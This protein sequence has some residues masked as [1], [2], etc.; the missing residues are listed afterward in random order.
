[1][2]FVVEC[3]ACG[4]QYTF[5]EVLENETLTESSYCVATEGKCNMYK[6]VRVNLD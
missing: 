2:E 6:V 3:L 1:M 4:K 5:D